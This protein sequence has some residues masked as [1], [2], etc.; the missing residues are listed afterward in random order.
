MILSR[1][2]KHVKEQNWFAVFIDFIIVVFGVFIGIQVA[3]WNEAQV[4]FQQET[5]ALIELRKELHGSI[6]STQARALAYKQ[7][8]DAGKRSLAF[9][10][11]Q[12]DCGERC[13]DRLVD[14]MHASQWQSL[15]VSYASYQNM[16]NQGFPASIVIVDAVEVYVAHSKN[17]AQSFNE[18]PLYRS[19][20]RQLI[21][22]EAQEYYWQYCWAFKDGVE[23]YNLQCPEGLSNHAAKLLVN[24]V[25]N[26]ANIK[27]HLTEWVGAIVS[28]PN[29]LVDQNKTAQK[30]IDLINQELETR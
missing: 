1:V 3:N 10:D 13:W 14:F 4:E 27:P 25:S 21:N 18:L 6:V 17:N 24:E 11:S 19:L 23:I 28:L 30:A 5:E 26:N 7:A 16:R 29:A 8:T 9:I 12:Q 15:N 20:V 2:T 22:V